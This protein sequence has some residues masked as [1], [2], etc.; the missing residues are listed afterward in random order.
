MIG[1]KLAKK[2]VGFLWYCTV[3]KKQDG[4]VEAIWDCCI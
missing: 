2:S 1:G 4:L 3:F